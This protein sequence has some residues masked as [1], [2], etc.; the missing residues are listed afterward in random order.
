M[1]HVFW[2]FFL[3]EKRIIFKNKEWDNKNFAS[4]D[5]VTSTVTSFAHQLSL[6][7]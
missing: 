6:F 1:K 7:F 3:I 2:F 4:P 5:F